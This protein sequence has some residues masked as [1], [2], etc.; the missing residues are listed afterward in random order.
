MTNS[1]FR[2]FALVFSLLVITAST[3]AQPAQPPCKS[4]PEL[5]QFDFWVGEWEVKS[6]QAETGP[7]VGKSRIESGVDG[8]VVLESW[9]SP[10]GFT[11][12]SWNF[13]DRAQQKWRQVWIDVTGR[14]VEYSGTY[15]DNVMS[16]EGEIALANGN[17]FKSR[18]KF[19]NLG[20]NKVR[21]FAERSVDDG[22]TWTTTVDLIYFRKA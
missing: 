1:Y 11:G 16:L 5:R 20:P 22:K 19:F 7:T 17:R 14:K 3:N 8:C 13:Y 10:G 21:Q 9:E 6:A 18:M 4:L 12:R 15:K 2:P